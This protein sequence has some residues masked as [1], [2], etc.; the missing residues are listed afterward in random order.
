MTGRN[1]TALLLMA[2]VAAMPV[3]A[4]AQ[5]WQNGGRGQT[6]AQRGYDGGQH[7]VGS[8]D[9]PTP[10]NAA[11]RGQAR[12]PSVAQGGNANAQRPAQAGARPTIPNRPNG[13]ASNGNSWR[14]GDRQRVDAERGRRDLE[15]ARAQTG[16]QRMGTDR[17]NSDSRWNDRDGNGRGR[18]ESWSGNSGVNNHWND[19]R[20]SDGRWN[21]NRQGDNR[22]GDNHWNNGRWDNQRWN[23][24]RWNQGGR[25]RW[26]RDWRHD[27][28]YD[29]QRYRYS[30]R[31]IYRAPRYYAPYGH[32]YRRWNYGYQL[33]AYYY[34]RDYWIDDP[35]HYR[36]P[37]VYGPYQWVRYYDDALLVDIGSGLIQDI[38]YSF[39]WR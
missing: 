15:R 26:D 23:D 39:F 8:P 32:Q 16:Q 37:P 20:P 34:V 27:N 35:W 38:I 18:G 4:Q 12:Q 29:W 5:A 33:P 6:N 17:R 21:G 31:Q 3:A 2:G 10:N 7:R 13:N 11:Q 30:N 9:R 22:W 24:D 28:R 14:S 36:L 19:R 1:W 25:N